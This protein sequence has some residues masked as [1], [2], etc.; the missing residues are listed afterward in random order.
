MGHT[1]ARWQTRSPGMA[2]AKGSWAPV[3]AIKCGPATYAILIAPPILPGCH[4]APCWRK[5]GGRGI[6]GKKMPDRGVRRRRESALPRTP[7]S[8]LVS[9]GLGR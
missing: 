9:H 3:G 5:A 6:Y 4:R 7:E 2:G 8:D 1:G